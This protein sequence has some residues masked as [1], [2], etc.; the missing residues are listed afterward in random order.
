MEEHFMKSLTLL[1]DLWQTKVYKPSIHKACQ[2]IFYTTYV[3]QMFDMKIKLDLA[4][5]GHLKI[6]YIMHLI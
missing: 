1:K 6:V 5:G 2:H 3:W 4:V